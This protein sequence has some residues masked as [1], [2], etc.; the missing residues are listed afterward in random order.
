MQRVEVGTERDRPEIYTEP[1]I[2]TAEPVNRSKGN[3]KDMIKRSEFIHNVGAAICIASIL[4]ALK[5]KA[6]HIAYF[7]LFWACVAVLVGVSIFYFIARLLSER[8]RTKAVRSCF[9]PYI[10]GAVIWVSLILFLL[11][12][13]S[14]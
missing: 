2:S 12:L 6:G 5:S 8:W 4:F 1:M 7:I 3:E 9:S 13:G 14:S 11:A 10:I